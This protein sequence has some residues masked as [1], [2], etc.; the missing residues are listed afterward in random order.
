MQSLQCSWKGKKHDLKVHGDSTIADLK[1]ILCEMT[2]VLPEKQKLLGLVR[3]KLVPDDTAIASLNL[4][5]MHTFIM[6]G[7]AEQDMI[8]EPLGGNSEVVDVSVFHLGL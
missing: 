2:L 5:E 7:T 1:E 8:V 6:M 3:G 4:K